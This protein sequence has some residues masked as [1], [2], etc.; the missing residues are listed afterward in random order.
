M[1]QQ[2][3][4]PIETAEAIR[5][6][7]SDPEFYSY[8]LQHTIPDPE[9]EYETLFKKIKKSKLEL[10][11]DHGI[12]GRQNFILIK[13]PDVVIYP[14]IRKTRFMMKDG[15]KF[16]ELHN[17]ISDFFA[18]GGNYM[19]RAWIVMTSAL[20]SKTGRFLLEHDFMISSLI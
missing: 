15:K 1:T 6:S 4:P 12:K 7:M 13:D 9:P 8:V 10:T 20:C 17:N 16:I 2:I 5:S 14:V 11:R 18:D 3:L 19:P